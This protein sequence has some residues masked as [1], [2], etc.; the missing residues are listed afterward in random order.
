MSPSPQKLSPTNHFSKPKTYIKSLCI[1]YLISIILLL[2]VSFLLYKIKFEE[3]ITQIFVY[4]IYIISCLLGGFFIGKSIGQRR[5][6]WGLMFGLVYFIVLLFISFCIPMETTSIQTETH[7]ETGH[8]LTVLA[9]CL[10]SGCVG[11][12]IS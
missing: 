1:S 10:A 9:I 4:G 12:M 2:F 7:Q 6:L 8:I 5:F 3:N 11:G